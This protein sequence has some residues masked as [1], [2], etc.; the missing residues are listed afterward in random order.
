MP[1]AK[2]DFSAYAL[3]KMKCSKFNDML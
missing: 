2:T 1:M 3:R